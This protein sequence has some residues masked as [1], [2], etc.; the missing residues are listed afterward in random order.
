MGSTHEVAEMTSSVL[1]FLLVTCL[2]FF[3]QI[4]LINIHVTDII[5]GNPSIILGLIWTIILH[6][7]VSHFHVLMKITSTLVLTM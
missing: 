3:P 2:P 1:C 5:E 7:H 4:K 6:F